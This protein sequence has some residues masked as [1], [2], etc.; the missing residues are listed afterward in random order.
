MRNASLADCCAPSGAPRLARLLEPD[1]FGKLDG[2]MQTGQRGPHRKSQARPGGDQDRRR[3]HH[4]D[5]PPPRRYALGGRRGHGRLA[6]GAVGTGIFAQAALHAPHGRNPQVPPGNARKQ[7]QDRPVGTEP[8][9][10]GPADEQPHAQEPRAEGQHRGAGAE[11]EQAHERIVAADDPGRARS[12]EEHGR[13]QVDVGQE[14]QGMI[15]PRRHLHGPHGDNFLHGPQ[16]ADRGAKC[17]PEEERED[18]RQREEGNHHSARGVVLVEDGLS[19][20]LDGPDRA[21]AAFPPEP[22]PAERDDGEQEQARSRPAF[23]GEQRGRRQG[24]RQKRQVRVVA[25]RRSR[26]RVLRLRNRMVLEF[27]RRQR[28]GRAGRQRGRENQQQQD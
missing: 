6:D 10:V 19:D 22:Q 28:I 27:G 5:Q 17:P 9:A 18:Q 16:R 25:P 7:R 20:V 8:A 11:A 21:D 14:S 13:S 2:R 12:R 24:R 23:H 26:R 4:G 1:L 15:D 3:A